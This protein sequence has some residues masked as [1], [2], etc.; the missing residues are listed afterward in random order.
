M[1]KEIDRYMKHAQGIDWIKE[2]EAQGVA[3]DVLEEL[4]QETNLRE[5]IGY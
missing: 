3:G 4:R 1:E 2:L 5:C